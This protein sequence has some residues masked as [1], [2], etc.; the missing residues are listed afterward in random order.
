MVLF[1]LSVLP[2]DICILELW[3]SIFTIMCIILLGMKRS[4]E[5]S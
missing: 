5:F 1:K 4:G 3:M 2:K